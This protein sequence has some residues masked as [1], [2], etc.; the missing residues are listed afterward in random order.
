M[1]RE[2]TRFTVRDYVY[3]ERHEPAQQQPDDGC[4]AVAGRECTADLS[5]GA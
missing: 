5:D 2:S 1:A 4:Q 3:R